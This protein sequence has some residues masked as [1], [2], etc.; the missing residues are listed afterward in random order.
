MPESFDTNLVVI[1]TKVD[2]SI[3]IPYQFGLSNLNLI[4]SS[5]LQCI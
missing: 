5:E 2:T 1:F 4:T 3:Y